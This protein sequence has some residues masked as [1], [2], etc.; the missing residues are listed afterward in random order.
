MLLAHGGPS[1]GAAAVETALGAPGARWALGGRGRCR[2]RAGC[3]PSQWEGACLFPVS[4]FRAP[5]REIASPGSR[6]INQRC[7][8]YLMATYLSFPAKNP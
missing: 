2:D 6:S 8:L 3:Q 4:R 5:N 1:A 7:E